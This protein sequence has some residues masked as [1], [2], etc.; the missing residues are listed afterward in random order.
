MLTARD[1][2]LVAAAIAPLMPAFA[3]AD[4]TDPRNLPESAPEATQATIYVF[5]R[6]DALIHGRSF[7][8][9]FNGVQL[10]RRRATRDC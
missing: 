9:S 5:R 1:A 8:V 3:L 7:F 4:T 2:V 10:P 6:A